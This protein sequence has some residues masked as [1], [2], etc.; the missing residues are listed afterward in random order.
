MNTNIHIVL[1]KLPGQTRGVEAYTSE[2]GAKDLTAGIMKEKGT[3]EHFTVTAEALRSLE[4][5]YRYT[6]P[7]HKESQSNG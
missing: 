3:Y 1:Y 7:D 6:D 4:A 5:G 2:V